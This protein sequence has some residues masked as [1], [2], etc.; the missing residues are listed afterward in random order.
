MAK[1]YRAE[2]MMD[3]Y[4]ARNLTIETPRTLWCAT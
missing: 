3:T 4:F 2:A 1:S